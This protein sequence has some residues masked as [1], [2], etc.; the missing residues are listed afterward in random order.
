MAH[1]RIRKMG[2]RRVVV[3]AK[4]VKTTTTTTA[5]TT[6]KDHQAA[7]PAKSKP[8][9]RKRKR[10]PAE[11]KT[12]PPAAKGGPSRFAQWRRLQAAIPKHIK[13]HDDVLKVQ[14]LGAKMSRLFED[15]TPAERARTKAWEEEQTAKKYGPKPKPKTKRTKRA[16]KAKPKA[17]K[18]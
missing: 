14:E 7:K 15:M 2:R 5:T 17:K 1:A 3:G 8:V 11:H 6:S 16:A 10:K 4:T 13:D 12:T 9:H 18:S